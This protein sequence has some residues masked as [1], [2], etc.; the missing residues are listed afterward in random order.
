MYV[1]FNSSIVCILA[2]DFT[3]F[4]KSLNLTEVSNILS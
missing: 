3:A 1:E 2:R 4:H